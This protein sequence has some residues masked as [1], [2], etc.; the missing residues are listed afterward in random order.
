MR[1]LLAAAL[2]AFV[3][4]LQAPRLRCVS[5]ARRRSVVAGVGQI[6][7]VVAGVGAAAFAWSALAD[8]RARETNAAARAEAVAASAAR[9]EERRR[10]AFVETRE[11]WRED[12][13]RAYDG[14]DY[15]GPI[16][17]GADGLVFNV[18][19]GRHFY[20]PGG[21]YHSMAGRDASRQLAKNRLDGDADYAADDES[22]LNLAERASLA[23][24][25]YSFK[26]KYDIVGALAPAE[27][28]GDSG[29][30]QG[31]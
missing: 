16:L 13:L 9:L 17:L 7:E 18:W 11:V 10:N 29:G 8:G 6:V 22:P 14:A 25:V 5:K 28:A 21:A 3:A 15:D 26:G 30:G 4:P 2:L 1:A 31:T 27:G 12:D 24:W 19:R 20:A 23:A